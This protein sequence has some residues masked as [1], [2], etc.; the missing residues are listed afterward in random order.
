M[1]RPEQEE[2]GCSWYCPNAVLSRP[3]RLDHKLRPFRADD[4]K[5]DVRQPLDNQREDLLNL[6]PRIQ[7][8]REFLVGEARDS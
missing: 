1:P 6:E 8:P 3:I 2:T 4:L 7:R 5:E